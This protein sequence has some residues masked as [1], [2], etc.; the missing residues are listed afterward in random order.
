MSEGARECSTSTAQLDVRHSNSATRQAHPAPCCLLTGALPVEDIALEPTDVFAIPPARVPAVPADPAP[1]DASDAS[2]HG[3]IHA[4]SGPLV[5][6]YGGSGG[7]PGGYGGG[8]T[9]SA[10]GNTWSVF[11]AQLN[12][13]DTGAGQVG[14]ASRAICILLGR[15]AA[16]QPSVP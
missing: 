1:G 7:P 10:H 9:G 3:V 4:G 2:A 15:C 13:P 6:L 11:K 12:V 16:K 5:G 14:G 8:G